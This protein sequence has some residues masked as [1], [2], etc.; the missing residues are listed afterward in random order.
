LSDAIVGKPD[1]NSDLEKLF[2]G[3]IM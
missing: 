2:D 1:L 3:N